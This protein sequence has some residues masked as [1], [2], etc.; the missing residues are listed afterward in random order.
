MH[1]S[2]IPA[3]LPFLFPVA[4]VAIW[5][6]VTK[7]LALMSGW[8]AL[9]DR[10]PDRPEFRLLVLRMQSGR[11]GSVVNYSGCLTLM[12][13][14]TGLRVSTW[15]IFAPFQSPFLVPWTDIHAES[16]RSLFLRT[17]QLR[18]GNPQIGQLTLSARTWER[19]LRASPDANARLRPRA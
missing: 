7:L 13:T 6:F 18:F 4:F 2:D 12:A 1:E 16:G 14:R 3:W 10:Y 11:L 8:D 5:L 17:V 15:R 19:L 9:E